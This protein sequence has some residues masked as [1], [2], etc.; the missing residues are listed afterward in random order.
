MGTSVLLVLDFEL[1]V[2]QQGKAYGINYNS[3]FWHKLM[4]HVCSVF[5]HMVANRNRKYVQRIESW[6]RKNLLQH[7][8]YGSYSADIFPQWVSGQKKRAER[9]QKG[10]HV[11]TY[12]NI[13]P[14][15]NR[16]PFR[17]SSEH[18]APQQKSNL[19]S[20]SCFHLS[21]IFSPLPSLSKEPQLAQP[22][23]VW[24]CQIVSINVADPLCL[25]M[26]YT[27]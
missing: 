25:L 8:F 13:I 10:C 26:A 1:R 7:H 12:M 3:T 23:T 14:H 16:K 22:D 2:R 9:R 24:H 17:I 27:C 21:Y 18:F 20:P 15:F 4:V 6:C 5:L 11:L 19:F